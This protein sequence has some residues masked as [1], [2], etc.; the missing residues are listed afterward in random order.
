VGRGHW[1]GQCASGSSEPASREATAILKR[2]MRG[3]VL[4]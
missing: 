3:A 2:H 1:V 4:Q